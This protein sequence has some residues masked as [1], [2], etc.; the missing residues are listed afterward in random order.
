MSSMMAGNLGDGLP[1]GAL[2]QEL[3]DVLA[4]K[5]AVRIERIVST[6]Q[7]SPQDQWYDQ[8]SDEFVLL[9]AGTAGLLIEGEAKER[10]LQAGDWLLL[11]AHRRHRVT[12]TQDRPPT[13]WLALHF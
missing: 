9:V 3:F 2:P 8:D 5:G 6:G 11:P 12:W 13:I 1:A 10:V 7:A 4:E